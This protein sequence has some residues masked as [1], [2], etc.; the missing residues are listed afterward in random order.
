MKSYGNKP[1]D[2]F[3]SEAPVLRIETNSDTHGTAEIAKEIQL[4]I[5]NNN[6]YTE[7]DVVP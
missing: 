1:N 4:T 3:A 6:Q 7:Y 2:N 5:F